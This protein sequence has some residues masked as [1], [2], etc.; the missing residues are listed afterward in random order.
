MRS[1]QVWPLC[2]L[3]STLATASAVV[4]GRS[5][6]SHL[7]PRNIT[8]LEI[9]A[10]RVVI[11]AHTPADNLTINITQPC[12]HGHA[13]VISQNVSETVAATV[14]IIKARA[15]PG[16]STMCLICAVCIL[17]A[18]ICIFVAQ[19][20]SSEQ[21]FSR[22]RRC[23][24]AICS[25]LRRCRTSR[26]AAASLGELDEPPATAKLRGAALAPYLASVEDVC[27]CSACR[28]STSRLPMVHKEPCRGGACPDR[29][30]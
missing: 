16:R 18:A 1:I 12:A 23:A 4:A 6:T 25:C 13:H 28:L 20:L 3:V 5:E 11:A 22:C 17:Y 21:P 15:H 8:E 10:G 14:L 19:E 26:S 30:T 7:S 29:V 2:I 27:R 9:T 24:G